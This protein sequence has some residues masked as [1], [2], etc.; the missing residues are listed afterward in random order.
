MNLRTTVG[1]LQDAFSLTSPTL[2]RKG[3][4]SYLYLQAS[5]KT[6][7]LYLYSTNH[8]AETLARISPGSDTNL[9]ITVTSSG[10]ALVDSS[11]LANGLLGLEKDTEVTLSLT[12][13]GNQLKVQAGRVKFSLSTSPEVKD[14]GNKMKSLPFRVAPAMTLPAEELIQFTKRSRFCIPDDQ[15]GQ[16]ANL[17][18]LKLTS[19]E[20]AIATDGSI[21]VHVAPIKKQGKGPGFGNGL[22][23]PSDAIPALSALVTRSKKQTVD[24]ILTPELNKVVFKF[25]DGTYFGA[26]TRSTAYP[27]MKPVIDQTP[28]YTFEVSRDTFTKALNRANFFVPS[29]STKKIL[30]LEFGTEKMSLYANGTETLSDDLDIEYKGAKPKDPIKIGMNISHL[31][32]IASGSDSSHLTFGF[33]QENAPLIVTDKNGEDDDRIDI[34]YVVMGVRLGSR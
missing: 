12:P 11:K 9:R 18:V 17:S 20:E 3:V 19:D 6:N 30:E 24:V 27:N 22:L 29:A 14:M 34:K 23:I 26:L 31:A 1:R 13:A 8:Q 4:S 10:E 16:R 21:A 32:N 5:E 15:T 28:K 2:D 7:T 33:T 25:A